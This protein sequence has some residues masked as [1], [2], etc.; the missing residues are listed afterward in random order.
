MGPR[1]LFR[2]SVLLAAFLA[3]GALWA[4][5]SSHAAV[6]LGSA[7]ATEP[8]G[9]NS[10]SAGGADRGCLFIG[11]VLPGRDLVAPFRGVIVRWRVRLGNDTQTQS[12]R[13]RTVRR[14]DADQFT[15]ISSGG[16]ENVPAGIGTYTFPAQLTIAAGDQVGLENE[17]GPTI[18]SRALSPGAREF[19]Y[20]APPPP[21]GGSTPL[22]VFTNDNYEDT[23][24]VDVEPD[25]DCDGRGDETQD[26][27]LNDGPC[28]DHSGPVQTLAAKKL[29]DVDKAA[30]RDTLSEAGKVTLKG[31]V[32]VP[33]ASGLG[34]RT[35]RLRARAVK[36]KASTKSLAANTKT[37]VKVR[38]SRRAKKKVK[39]AIADSGARRI[40]LTVTAR[41]THGNASTARLSFKL[42][43]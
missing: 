3:A 22:P 14:I 26:S 43:D 32:K 27:D 16:L 36:T 12:I 24:N 42:T 7:L 11:D 4:A 13:I 23:F 6:T 20:P 10:C 40:R 9:T 5:A 17:G 2:V 21:D 19:V 30:I 18:E 35:F 41:D 25:I 34:F 37:K 28:G 38:L 8:D 33:A 15:V 29:Q 1:A 31:K 39:A